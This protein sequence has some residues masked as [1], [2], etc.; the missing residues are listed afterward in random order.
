VLDTKR[1]S[2]KAA[3]LATGSSLTEVHRIRPAAA[4]ARILADAGDIARSP[5]AAISRPGTPPP[6]SMPPAASMRHRLSRAG[7]R[8]LKPHA[9]HGCAATLPTSPAAVRRRRGEKAGNHRGHLG[10]VC[11]PARPPSTRSRPFGQAKTTAAAR[12][13]DESTTSPTE[14]AAR[15]RLPS[16]THGTPAA[17]DR[18]LA[19]LATALLTRPESVCQSDSLAVGTRLPRRRCLLPGTAGHWLSPLHGLAPR[20]VLKNLDAVRNRRR[21]VSVVLSWSD[22]QAG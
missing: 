16:T 12:H 8:R 11:N 1:T 19:S 7:N 6:R 22:V 2:M 10:G 5:A 9:L 13:V 20:G 18:H 4:A 14:A 15:S 3:V 17:T 21:G